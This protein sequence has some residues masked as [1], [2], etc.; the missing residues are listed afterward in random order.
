MRRV[1]RTEVATPYGKCV[2][3]TTGTRSHVLEPAEYD[4]YEEEVA[5]AHSDDYASE[6]WEEVETIT[7]FSLAIEPKV[8]CHK[9]WVKKQTS[10]VSLIDAH[11][12][13]WSASPA[14]SMRH[15]VKSLKV[16]NYLSLEK[17]LPTDIV[18]KINHLRVITKRVMLGDG[19]EE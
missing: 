14:T 11:F 1:V 4:Q 13:N 16:V 9:C 17:D 5:V 6:A 7:K 15:I 18:A 10:V 19:E 2:V 12:D 8:M 3:C